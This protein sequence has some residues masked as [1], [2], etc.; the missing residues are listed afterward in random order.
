MADIITRLKLESGEYDSKIKRAVTGLQRL[1]EEC[2]NAGGTLAILEKDQKQYVENLGRM[3]TVSKSAR[4]SIAELTSAYTELRV[5]YNRL[6]EAEKKGDFGKA[7]NSS[8]TQLKTRIMEGKNELQSIQ[9]E[10]SG[11]KFGK[12]GGVLDSIGQ[13]MG[14]NANITELLTSKTARMSAGIGAIIAVV[15]KATSEWIKY[16]NALSQQT[17]ITTVTTGLKG[18]NA[19]AMTDRARALVDT[20]GGDYREIINA[21]N[22]LMTQFGKS[23]DEAMELIRKGMQGM[24]QGDGPKL[25]S[26]IQQYA[27][28]FRDAG[29]SA[30][31][32]V[33]II[34]NSEGGIFT[35][36]NMNAIVMG[37][38]NI[39][40]MAN[41][42]SEAL[43]K[44]GI[45]GQKMSEQLNNGTITIFEALK[46]VTSAIQGV[47]SSSQAAGEVMQ[48][49]FGRQGAMAGT[50]LGEAITTLNTNLE[51][52]KKQTG[53]LGEANDE[54]YQSY[55]ELN[56]A[57]REAFGYDGWEEMAKGIK[58][59]L[60]SALADVI[61]GLAKVRKGWQ[62]L[63]NDITGKGNSTGTG[64]VNYGYN[65]GSEIGKTIQ[66]ADSKTERKRLYDQWQRQIQSELSK[67]GQEK[68][69]K[70]KDG[71]DVY[72]V[73][74]PAT[75]NRNRIRYL[76]AARYLQQNRNSLINGPAPKPKRGG[77]TDN[78]PKTR[79]GS[80]SSKAAT[81]QETEKELTIQQQIAELEKEAYTASGERRAEIGAQIRLLDEEL[82]RQKAIRDELHGIVTEEKKIEPL[83]LGSTSGLSAY[84]GELKKKQGAETIGSDKWTEAGNQMTAAT[85]LSTIMSSALAGGLDGKQVESI[86]APLRDALS[87]GL[88]DKNKLMEEV[89]Y[90]LSDINALL[91]EKGLEPI[92]LNVKTNGIDNV[93]ES[94]GELSKSTSSASSA[95][96]TL[97]GAI[98]SLEDP[99]AKVA[100][101]VMQA[102]G[103]VALGFSHALAT[104]KDPWS[105]IAFAAAGTATM[106]STIAAI[107]SA[108]GYAQGGLVDGRGGGFVGGLA[109]SGDNV[110]NVR[111]DS[112]ELVLNHAQQN[113]L[114]NALRTDGESRDT[115]LH[116]IVKGED[117]YLALGNYRHRTGKGE[118][119]RSRR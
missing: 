26:M 107:H 64:S 84:I 27:P 21:A 9:G 59:K 94:V 33:A 11:S 70:D 95:M 2:R 116:A 118:Y 57:I 42:T 90:A 18:D 29:I 117:I 109:Y 79:T 91:R 76:Q 75:Q 52:T 83:N 3:E 93:K 96:T 101:I 63:L 72:Y 6:T 39:R 50:K 14:L 68:H 8:L 38:K 104:P 44:L 5:Q 48:Q 86:T 46:Q 66:A 102:I 15:G 108:T 119:V 51:E 43:A 49:V 98:N 37:I 45:D 13:K 87:S 25:L 35:D 24:I 114:A 4:G 17:Q 92:T 23:G 36:Q 16:N 10:L 7:L 77:G 100:G 31:Q 115:Q 81:V 12:F 32:L 55:T 62:G 78:P 60:V 80:R 73:D 74:D 67:V 110:G 54:L 40:L 89:S 1:E 97:G 103:N 69:H 53:E 105:W 41:S 58:S 82:A 61:E 106:I 99:S 34:H 47:D 71:S 85:N 28:S 56:T 88:I 19:N 30:S 22:T 111:L 20:Y 113:N 112:G 65:F